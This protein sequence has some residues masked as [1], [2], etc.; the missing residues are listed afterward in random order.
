MKVSELLAEQQAERARDEAIDASRA[1][2]VC[3]VLI[4]GIALFLGWLS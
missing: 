1:L 3:A 4:G 2:V